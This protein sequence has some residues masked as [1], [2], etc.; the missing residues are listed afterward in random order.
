VNTV[1]STSWQLRSHA[2]ASFNPSS[3]TP[4]TGSSL[5]AKQLG[6]GEIP[7]NRLEDLTEIQL[8]E[9]ELEE[10][11]QR[12]DLSWQ[13]RVRAI[14]RI[15][16]LRS[17]DAALEGEKWGYAETGALCN[18]AQSNVW[19]ATA[20][21]KLIDAGD[22]EIIKQPQFTDA[23]RVLLRRK[24]AAAAG[25]FVRAMQPGQVIEIVDRE[26]GDPGDTSEDPFNVLPRQAEYRVE[27]HCADCIEWLH[28]HLK[29][30]GEAVDHIYC[31]PPYGIEMENLQNVERTEA[32]HDVNE[33]MNLLH[34][35]IPLAYEVLKPTGFLVMWTDQMQWDFVYE[36]GMVNGFAVQRWPLHWVKTDVCAN[37]AAD[38]NWT[39]STEIAIVMRRESAILKQRQP[40]NYWIGSNDKRELGVN[41]PFWKPRQLHQWVLGAIALPGEMILDPFA[42]AGSIPLACQQLRQPCTAIEKVEAHFVE[43]NDLLERQK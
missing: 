22:A 25:Q 20:V 13:E 12:E 34:K 19:Y 42:G 1:T 15:H 21:A 9:L 37:Q 2:T 11:V 36:L 35:F 31:D 23:V 26:P 38:W 29:K 5:A 28:A 40:R 8:N 27:R 39:K 33:N 7:F 41:H 30:H 6:W 14:A 18:M 32:E 3:S 16:E 17:R 4:R 43:M 10:N 24:E